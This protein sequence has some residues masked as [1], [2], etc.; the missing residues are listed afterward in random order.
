M[1][2]MTGWIHQKL[3]KVLESLAQITDIAKDPETPP[4]YRKRL[5]NRARRALREG[6]ALLLEHH[7][8]LHECTSDIADETVEHGTVGLVALLD[9]L[10]I[11]AALDST[12]AHPDF[13]DETE[14]D[15]RAPSSS[16]PAPQ[17]LADVWSSR[18]RQL[19]IESVLYHTTNPRTDNAEARFLNWVLFN[20]LRAKYADTALIF[21]QYLF[22]DAGLNE[23]EGTA[24]LNRL[25]E[26][27]VLYVD[28]QLGDSKRIALRIIVD[29]NDPRHEPPNH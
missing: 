6:V 16:D 26:E 11:D 5:R 29:G 13:D 8:R 7:G 3:V 20:L 9:R 22:A 17:E 25:I 4:W 24:L 15:Q 21:R 27:E 28:R 12:T 2:D 14:D 19:V 18:L 23:Q 10:K 1:L